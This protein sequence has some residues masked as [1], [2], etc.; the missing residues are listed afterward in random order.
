MGIT[1]SVELFQDPRD[2]AAFILGVRNAYL[3]GFP[4]STHDND[5]GGINGIGHV[6]PPR[7]LVPGSDDQ[8][9]TLTAVQATH[10]LS[11]WQGTSA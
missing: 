1:L 9:G 6:T 2:I 8:R 11:Q 10:G 7:L 4:A 3:G 5:D